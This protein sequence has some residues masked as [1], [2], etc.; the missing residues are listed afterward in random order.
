MPSD[1]PIPESLLTLVAATTVF[2]V[3]FTLGL[4]VRLREFRWVLAHAGLIARALFCVLVA[5]PALA[6]VVCR[7]L[8]LPRLAE[9][10]VVLMAIAPGAPVALR[11]SLDAGGHRAFAP[12][13]QIMVALLAVVSMPL[14]IAALNHV[15]AGHASIS[16]VELA[17]Q[18][19]VAQLLPL[20][21]GMAVCR[22]ASALAE[23]LQPP[24]LRIATALLVLL[25]VLALIDV[26]EV[27][28]HAGV[29]TALAIVI[30]TLGALAVGHAMGGPEPATRTAVAI[31][32]AARNP[33]LA[34]LVV[35]LNQAAPEIGRA[36][37]SY[38]LVSAFT[39]VPYVMWRR[40]AG[41][42]ATGPA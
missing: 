17:K 40:R 32:S 34:L 5:V 22:F 9:I 13:L 27:V 20:S 39:I 33:G 31:T 21:I 15:Y 30:V 42:P 18:V 11:R 26:G 29:R 10:G 25:G 24:L 19:F 14:S 38:L 37:L 35:A 6:L 7:T 12:A 28:L 1:G 3:M 41:A 16:P 4:G 23:R 8:E 36:V 2:T